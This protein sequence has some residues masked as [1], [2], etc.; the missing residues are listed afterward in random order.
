MLASPQRVSIGTTLIAHYPVSDP[1]DLLLLGLEL[2][3][4][5]D[6][7]IA[8]LGETLQLAHVL[9]LGRGWG[10]GRRRLGRFLATTKVLLRPYLALDERAAPLH[11]RH[12]SVGL[13]RLHPVGAS[14]RH[15][16][17]LPSP[18]SPFT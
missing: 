5:E 15:K 16:S 8:Q 2:L 4:A 12:G 9:G 3:V 14:F 18:S 10:R 13:P 17:H 6:A 11:A 7:L 1:K